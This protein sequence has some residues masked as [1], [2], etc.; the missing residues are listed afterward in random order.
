L[1]QGYPDFLP[2]VTGSS[3][4]DRIVQSISFSENPFIEKT[5]TFCLYREWAKREDLLRSAQIIHEHAVRY[6]RGEGAGTII[7][8][9]FAHFRSDIEAQFYVE[10]ERKYPYGGLRNLI[11]MS[12]GLPRPLLTALKNIY[13]WAAFSEVD[14]GQSPEIAMS[15]QMD[16]IDE[17]SDWFFKD[18]R[19]PGRN[20][21]LIKGGVDRLGYLLNR[22]RFSDKP[23]ESAL[24]AFSVEFDKLD[25]GTAQIVRAAEEW[26][27]I[28]SVPQGRKDRNASWIRRTFQLNPILAPRWTLPISRRGVLELN[29]RE[30]SLIF[31]TA[32][33][34][35]DAAYRRFVRERVDRMSAPYFGKKKPK[36]SNPNPAQETLF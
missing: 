8:K 22:L 32:P 27:M 11:W 25:E 18:A 14:S 6:V 21:Q 23:V 31:S 4:I 20:G 26:S 12:A 15:I 33:A 1:E 5:S 13:G 19:A 17:T 7:D 36:T 9:R 16:G 3:D 28:I 30:V 35:T 24:S 29:P 34:E 2:G 10:L